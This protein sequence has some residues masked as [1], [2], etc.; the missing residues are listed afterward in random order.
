ML[1]KMPVLFN[2]LVKIIELNDLEEDRRNYH[3]IDAI[4]FKDRIKKM[5]EILDPILVKKKCIYNK[6]ING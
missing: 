1:K 4:R 3:L 5:G 6:L 2:D